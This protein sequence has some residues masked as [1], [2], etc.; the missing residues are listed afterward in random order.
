MYYDAPVEGKIENS[1]F[2]RL[3]RIEDTVRVATSTL[4]PETRASDIFVLIAGDNSLGNSLILQD[5]LIILRKYSSKERTLS[6]GDTIAVEIRETNRIVL[7]IYKKKKGDISLNLLSPSAEDISVRS[8]RDI[9]I[10]GEYILLIRPVIKP[11]QEVRSYDISK[12][13][14]QHLYRHQK[15]ISK[16]KKNLRFVVTLLFLILTG[17]SLLFV[18]SSKF[19]W[20]IWMGFSQKTFWDWLELLIIPA[21]LT[22]GV[23]WIN[24]NQKQNQEVKMEQ[25]ANEK[26][27]QRYLDNMTDLLL[28][29]KLRHSEKT[30]EER[31]IARTRTITVLRSVDK[32]RKGI[33]IRFLYE[34]NL[35]SGLDDDVILSLIAT[36]LEGANLFGAFLTEINLNGTNLYKANLQNTTLSKSF[37]RGCILSEANLTGADLFGADLSYATLENTDLTNADFCDANLTE[38]KLTKKQLDKAKINKNTILPAKML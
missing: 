7:A 15:K 11:A 17:Y 33:V 16:S 26:M 12:N 4:P 9:K 19:Q 36:D 24:Q 14:N 34:A 2:V 31:Q 25:D 18:F 1:R 27:L 38:A 23:L 37:L 29:G 6:D 5:D 20:P 13:F 28:R 32:E 21:V 10:I 22:F 8:D 30:S 3:P 35:I